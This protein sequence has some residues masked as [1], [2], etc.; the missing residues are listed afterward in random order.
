MVVVDKKEG[1]VFNARAAFEGIS[2]SLFGATGKGESKEAAQSMARRNLCGVFAGSMLHTGLLKEYKASGGVRTES[3]VDLCKP[4][5]E[6]A[7]SVLAK[8]EYRCLT[9]SSRVL[10]NQT[11]EEQSYARAARKEIHEYAKSVF[12]AYDS[13][14]NNG[15]MTIAA[16]PTQAAPVE[17]LLLSAPPPPPIAPSTEKTKV[18]KRTADQPSTSSSAPPTKKKKIVV[19]K[20]EEDDNCIDLCS[21]S[22]SS[23]G[24]EDV[25]EETTLGNA[26]KTPEKSKR[27]T[28]TNHQSSLSDPYLAM[29]SMYSEQDLIGV[30][31]W[32]G[33]REERRRVEEY[34][35]KFSRNSFTS[36]DDDIWQHYK[37]NGQDDNIYTWKMSVRMSLLEVAQRIFPGNSVNMFAVG[38]TI[39]GCGSYNS[40]MDLCLVVYNRDG[41]ITEGQ[42]FAKANLGK[43]FNE[44]KRSRN[45]V[46]K[47]QFIRHAV[48]PIIKMETVAPNSL[49][50][51]INM[52]NIAGVYNSHLMHYYSR[53]DDRF[54]ALCL[55]VKHWAIKAEV[56]DSLSGTFNSYSLIL[57][58]LHYLQCGVYPAIL[59]NLQF[60]YPSRFSERPD[61]GDLNLF[62][63]FCPALP[64]RVLNE[65]SVG[66]ILIGFF[67]Y[68]S[69]FDFTNNAI[70]IRK[71]M[72]FPRS[73]LPAETTKAPLYIEEPFDGKNTARCVRREFIHVIRLAFEHAADAFNERAPSLSDIRVHV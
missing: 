47:C 33:A 38:S 64:S 70:S 16:A 5:F 11:E 28:T 46:A 61:L 67:Q 22:E 59:P 51:D 31:E 71:G 30:T 42:H 10:A 57:L 2:S 54:P 43:M 40:D 4:I 36:F 18:A 63:D 62:G 69:K 39:N 23:D 37:A 49:E 29:A 73:L 6:Y 41:S 21:S 8:P 45:I 58:V 66:E 65:Q 53:V 68:Y 15:R 17:P 55:I 72:V 25:T 50:V 34:K 20:V 60:L 9:D 7:L 3:L 32:S 27:S 48:V 24:C 44:L 1:D 35:R 56:N 14:I 26:V 12:H 19:V 13:A 52:N